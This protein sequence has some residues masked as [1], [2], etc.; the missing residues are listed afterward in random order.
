M[1]LKQI[2]VIQWRCRRIMSDYPRH[3]RAR[4]VE[5]VCEEEDQVRGEDSSSGSVL[6]LPSLKLVPTNHR[7]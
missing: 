7:A 1:P 4:Q 2:R 6:T 5:G 3:D